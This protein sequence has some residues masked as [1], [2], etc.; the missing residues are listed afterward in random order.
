M[1]WLM[2]TFP[3]SIF[4]FPGNI[5]CLCPRKIYFIENFR[6]HIHTRTL[7]HTPQPEA[8]RDF[9]ERNAMYALEE[10]RICLC[11]TLILTYLELK[12]LQKARR[13]SDFFWF[14]VKT[15]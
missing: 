12:C 5:D 4:Y 9:R 3:F 8:D 10:I 11:H 7:V 13:L 2:S 14:N 15:S 6:T 1:S